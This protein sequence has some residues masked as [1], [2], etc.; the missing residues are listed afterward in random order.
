MDKINIVSSQA[1]L[2]MSSSSADIRSMS[3]SPLVTSLF[4][5]R[6][7]KTAPDTGEPPFHFIYTMDF[8]MLHDSPNLVVHRTEIWAVWG[9]SLD[10]RKFGVFW[11]SS[12]I[13]ARTLHGVPLH[14]PAGTKSLPDTLRIAGSSMTSWSSIEEVSKRCQKNFLLC[15]NSEITACI[16]DLF[17]SFCE[18]VYA[19][20]FFNV[21]QQQTTGKVGNSIMCLWA[22]NFCLQQWKNY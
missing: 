16:A 17:N 21:V 13:V 4:K 7:Y 5:N 3:S 6:L 9:H 22:G 11:H 8:R 2:Q 12:S 10:A 1:A 14:C 18:A 20:A 15:N 19:I